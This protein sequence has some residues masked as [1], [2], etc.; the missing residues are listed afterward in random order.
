MTN[1]LALPGKILTAPCFQLLY[2]CLLTLEHSNKS[3]PG[4]SIV[5][6][7]FGLGLQYRSTQA[8]ETADLCLC[9]QEGVRMLLLT[10]SNVIVN[11]KHILVKEN[12]VHCKR[13]L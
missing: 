11:V 9:A 6:V 13:L 4:I 10:P 7:S 3:N 2:I 1:P 12:I 5:C 8:K